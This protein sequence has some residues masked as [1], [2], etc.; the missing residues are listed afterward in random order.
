M[1][2]EDITIEDWIYQ[3]EILS[4]EIPKE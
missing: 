1:T 2:N 4:E 3:L